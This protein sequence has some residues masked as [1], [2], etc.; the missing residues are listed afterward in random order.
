MHFRALTRR[1]LK[2]P[3]LRDFG[4]LA[5]GSGMTQAM[6]ALSM[7]LMARIFTPVEL[8]EFFLIQGWL[9]SLSL[10]GLPGVSTSL[11]TSV[12]LGERG[13]YHKAVLLESISALG[14]S[15]CLL[16]LG[17][18][19]GPKQVHMGKWAYVMAALVF[20]VYVN[21]CG[22]QALAGLRQYHKLSLAQ[23][24]IKAFNLTYILA[25]ALFHLGIIWLLGGQLMTH[26]MVNFY[27]IVNNWN[28]IG[29]REKYNSQSIRYG[30]HLTLSNL[31]Q[32]PMSQAER[33]LVGLFFGSSTLAVFGL[34]EIIYINLRKLANL[35]QNLYYPRLIHVP[36]NRLY[37]YLINHGAIWTGCFIA[38]GFLLAVILPWLYPFLLGE[39]YKESAIFAVLY[40]FAFSVGVP[41][42]FITI[43]LRH[44]R[45]TKATYLFGLLR[46]P[47]NLLCLAACFSLWGV[48]G[49]AA[50][51]GIANIA[52]VV[53]GIYL[54]QNFAEPKVA[55]K[56]VTLQGDLR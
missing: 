35:S 14:G 8:G 2:A 52:Y 17:I 7:I 40:S 27:L 26:S 10:W 49:L 32:P 15:L 24:I 47:L 16:G 54:I 45:A 39:Q 18:W 1:C 23:A 22:F 43:Y 11:V 34:G 53:V 29:S 36:V 25:C 46:M 9:I 4:W 42:Y 30:L 5:G 28:K 20:P 44:T 6:G 51:R 38:A 56:I 37:S 3:G 21:D 33:L 48:F 13:T 19:L 12:A 50:G 55:G 41:N 31:L